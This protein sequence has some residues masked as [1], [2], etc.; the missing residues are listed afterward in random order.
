MQ[1]IWR[2]EAHVL[3]THR[4]TAFE[5]D[6]LL[7]F[8]MKYVLKWSS[9]AY[10]LSYST[11]KLNLWPKIYVMLAIPLCRYQGASADSMPMSNAKKTHVKLC[12][13]EEN[14]ENGRILNGIHPSTLLEGKIVRMKWGSS[15]SSNGNHQKALEYGNSILEPF[16]E[17]NEDEKTSQEN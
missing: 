7:C 9:V 14:L 2:V 5:V 4:K 6:F 3:K 8:S 17:K 15:T 16:R 13:K 10:I 12:K 11:C 1:R